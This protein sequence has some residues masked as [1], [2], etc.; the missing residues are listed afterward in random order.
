MVSNNFS[1]CL[2]VTNFNLNYVRTGKIEWAEKFLGTSLSKGDVPTFF[3]FS[4][5]GRY[6]LGRG[7]KALKIRDQHIQKNNSRIASMAIPCH[8]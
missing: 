3:V 7:P 1:V 2:S 8:L 6:G 5:G 4:A